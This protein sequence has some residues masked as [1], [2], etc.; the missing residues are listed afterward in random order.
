MND[1]ELDDRGILRNCGHCGRRNRMR[2]EGLGQ[3]FHCAQCKNQLSPLNEPLDARSDLV[4]DGLI[5]RSKLPVL[6]D[7][8]AP[9]CGPC[10]MVAPEFRQVA[11]ETVGQLVLAKVNTEE[12]PSLAVRFRV[13]AIPTMVLFENGLE[14]ARQ[15]GAMP[16]PAIRKFIGQAQVAR[17]ERR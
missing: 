17:K 14:V 1:I 3:T 11:R 8:W 6:V 15:T 13:T 9:W 4:F 2:Y 7:F 10:K 16:A 5:S 12:V